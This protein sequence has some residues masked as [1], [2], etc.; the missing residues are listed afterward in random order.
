MKNVIQIVSSGSTREALVELEYALQKL[1]KKHMVSKFVY[2]LLEKQVICAPTTLSLACKTSL[3]MALSR[4][5]SGT[6]SFF[7]WI[8][9]IS[10]STN[11]HLFFI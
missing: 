9:F 6:P 1:Y 11:T 4:Q 10:V 3:R 2:Q 7:T 8:V 5:L